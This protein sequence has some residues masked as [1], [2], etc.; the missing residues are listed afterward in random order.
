MNLRLSHF[1]SKITKDE[2][3]DILEQEF[4]HF[5]PFEVILFLYFCRFDRLCVGTFP[6]QR[7]VL[8]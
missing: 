3:K 8:L 2:V 5:A 7:K 1:D 4:R 6:A